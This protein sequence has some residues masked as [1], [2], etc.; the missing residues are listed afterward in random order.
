MSDD[1]LAVD[2]EAER[3]VLS[4]L[5][6]HPE[7]WPT[8]RVRPE[9]FFGAGLGFIVEAMAESVRQHGTYDVVTILDAPAVDRTIVHGLVVDDTPASSMLARH[10]SRVA[11]AA[12]R[13]RR[14]HDLSQTSAALMDLSVDYDQAIGAMETRIAADD[15]VSGPP[16]DVQDFEQWAEIGAAAPRPWIIPGVIRRQGRLIVVAAE[17]IG[18]STLGLQAAVCCAIGRHPFR[19]TPIEPQRVLVVDLENDPSTA[20]NEQGTVSIGSPLGLMV[21]ART[22]V[23]DWQRNRLR[24]WHRDQGIDMRSRV[25]A[26]ALE[27]AIADNHPDLVVAGPLYKMFQ[28]V[29]GED[30]ETL[31]AS[32]QR[33]F[34]HLRTTYDIALWLEHHAPKAQMGSRPLDPFG[35]SLWMRWPDIGITLTAADQGS[36]KVGRFRRD[37]Y[38]VTGFPDELHRGTVWPWVGKWS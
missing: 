33:A 3:A 25:D 30:D 27:G 32:L 17:G 1:V 18:K 6:I 21:T 10:V 31:G 19:L 37:R 4:T 16:R 2:F 23:P 15:Y 9:D 34:D 26:D 24:I 36:L 20:V 7:L 12:R 14:I 38:S 13:R 29:K 28:R 35:T 8:V 11:E 22:Q 5:L